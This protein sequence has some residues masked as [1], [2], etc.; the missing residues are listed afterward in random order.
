MIH[1]DDYGLCST[2]YP[3]FS[4]DPFPNE[5]YRSNSQLYLGSFRIALQPLTPDVK[6]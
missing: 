4:T 3:D 2:A 1:G 6:L 5:V